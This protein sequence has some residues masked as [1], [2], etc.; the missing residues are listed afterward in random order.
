MT[1][2]AVHFPFTTASQ[3]RLLYETWQATQ[4][5]DLACR[6]AH[7]G[8]RTFYYWKARFTAEGYAGLEHFASRAPKQPHRID[9]AIESEVVELRR[10]HPD[11]GKQRLADEVAKA[12]DWMA[13][14]SP[15]TV[16]RILQDAQLWPS[17]AATAK[18]GGPNGSTAQRK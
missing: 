12:H 8:Q 3:R 13:L 15:N 2:P 7:V 5:V 9:Q 11:W 4:D 14:V 16:K 17:P 1:R 10:A 6:T 18:K